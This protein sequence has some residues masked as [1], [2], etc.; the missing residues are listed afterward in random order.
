MDAGCYRERVPETHRDPDAALPRA[1]APRDPVAVPDVESLI[2]QAPRMMRGGLIGSHLLLIVVAL[3]C[4]V[5]GGTQAAITALLAGLSVSVLMIAG[6]WLQMVLVQRADMMG[7][8]ATLAGFGVRVAALGAGLALW[9]AFADSHPMIRP[10]GV[11]AGC[12]AVSMGWLGGVL[13][14][15]SRLRVPIYDR[16][17]ESVGSLPGN[18]NSASAPAG[19]AH[20]GA[21]SD[22][23][24][25]A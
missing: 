19:G 17:D 21:T 24:P 18:G 9:L 13:G 14:T 16:V 22:G 20:A 8:A 15:Y 5:A 6:Q 11:V 23:V 12:C 3:V 2:G 7:M 4:C 1:S 25:Q 10:W